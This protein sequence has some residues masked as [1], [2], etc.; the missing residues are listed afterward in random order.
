MAVGVARIIGN[1]GGGILSDKIGIGNVFLVSSTI[2]IAA[3]I[4]FTSMSLYGNYKGN[5]LNRSASC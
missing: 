3:V 5:K 4:V 1:I 2:E